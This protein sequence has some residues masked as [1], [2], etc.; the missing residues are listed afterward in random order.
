[1]VNLGETLPGGLSVGRSDVKSFVDRVS[2]L[3]ETIS[4]LRKVAEAKSL[5]RA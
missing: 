5:S 2:K 3:R 1:M 4:L